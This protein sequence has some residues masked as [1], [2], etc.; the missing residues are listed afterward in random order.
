[1]KHELAQMSRLLDPLLDRVGEAKLMRL[2]Q[3]MAVKKGIVLR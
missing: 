2:G 1:M 3:E